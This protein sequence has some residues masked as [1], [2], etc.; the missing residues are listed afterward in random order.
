VLLE[1]LIANLVSNAILAIVRSIV[2]AH[3]ATISARPRQEGGPTWRSAS[4]DGGRPTSTAAF[5][6]IDYFDRNGLPFIIAVNCFD[7]SPKVVLVS[8]VRHVMVYRPVDT[9]SRG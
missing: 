3:D 4:P 1:R 9:A 8:L 2:T 7:G 5:A 6:S